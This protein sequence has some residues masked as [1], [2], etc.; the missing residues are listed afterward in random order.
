MEV[1]VWLSRGGWA[2][3]PLSLPGEPRAGLQVAVW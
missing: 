3:S 1:G 2:G